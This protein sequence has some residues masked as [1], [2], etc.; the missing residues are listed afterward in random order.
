MH[1]TETSKDRQQAELLAN[2]FLFQPSYLFLK[3]VESGF[4]L[5]RQS[6]IES[7]PGKLTDER[8]YLFFRVGDEQGTV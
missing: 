4:I 5:T 6:S 1:T 2:R 7:R 3:N 8:L